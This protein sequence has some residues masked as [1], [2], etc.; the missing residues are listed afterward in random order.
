MEIELRIDDIGFGKGRSLGQE[1]RKDAAPTLEGPDEMVPSRINLVGLRVDE[2]LSRL[3]PFLNHASLAG[4]TEVTI[5]H[6]LGTGIL[7]RAVRE[8][9]KG[10]PLVA[11]YRAGDRSEGGNGVT[12]ATLA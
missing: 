4:F 10:H 2:A 1:E 3:E 8:H 11:S 12:V 9:L 6:G 5:I 7:S